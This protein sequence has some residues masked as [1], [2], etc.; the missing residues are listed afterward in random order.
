MGE[1]HIGEAF[2]KVTQER[3]WKHRFQQAKIATEWESIVGRV[4]ATYTTEV[5]L[6]GSSLIIK[7]TMSA[8]KNEFVLRQDQIIASI[9]ELLGEEVIKEVIIS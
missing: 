6:L 9:H 3:H 4:A 7:T 8:L 1:Y 5:K 2:K